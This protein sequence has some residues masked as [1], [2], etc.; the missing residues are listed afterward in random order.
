MNRN[1]DPVPVIN[2]TGEIIPAFGLM[3]RTG[4][5]SDAQITVAKPDT[6]GQLVL[7][8]GPVSILA[9]AV[10]AATGY[11]NQQIIA[12]DTSDGTPAAGETWGA[13]NGSWLARKGNAGFE[14]DGGASLGKVNAVRQSALGYGSSY[15]G[16]DPD[17][18]YSSG[19]YLVT[20]TLSDAG[21]LFTDLLPGTYIFY[22]TVYAR[23][24]VSA[25]G[26]GESALVIIQM[27]NDTD[28]VPIDGSYGTL[29]ISVT[30][31]SIEGFVSFTS[32]AYTISETKTFKLQA[33]RG[34]TN[35]SSPAWT[36]AQLDGIGD[37]NVNYIKIA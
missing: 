27:N 28:N 36:S 13:K 16:E 14:I 18:S 24:K 37:R 33:Y 17:V 32:Y 22:A 21:A 29:P 8:N 35:G 25:L 12:F 7:V 30:G 34:G 20:D 1:F 11:G 5:N 15:I 9:N 4:V 31:R 10:G 26:A 23:G 19:N 6:D 2:T 3:R